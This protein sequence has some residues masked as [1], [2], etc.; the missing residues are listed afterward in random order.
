MCRKALAALLIFSWMILSVVDLVEDLDAPDPTHFDDPDDGPI[1]SNPFAG[2]LTRNI[3][4][5]AA[6]QGIRYANLLDG[7]TGGITIYKPHLAQTTSK[8]YKVFRVY[9]I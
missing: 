4:E 1:P 9:I 2:L 6:H 3:V 5:S 7:F 8:L